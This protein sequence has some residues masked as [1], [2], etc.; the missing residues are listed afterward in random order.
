[1][2]IYHIFINFLLPLKLY[3]SNVESLVLSIFGFM[4]ANAI[5]KIIN[6]I[7]MFSLILHI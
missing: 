6:I 2:S 7:I 4:Q 5:T 3:H 1:M